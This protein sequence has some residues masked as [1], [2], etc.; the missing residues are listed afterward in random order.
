MS[1]RDE[2]VEALAAFATATDQ[3]DWATIRSLLAPDAFAYSSSGP[4]AIVAQMQAHLGGCGPTQHLLGNHR[5]TI[6]GDTAR[7]LSSARVHHVGAGP[8]AGSSYE[9]LGDYDDSWVPGPGG[10]RIVRRKFEIRIDR[11]DF[12]VL[13]P[14]DQQGA[15]DTP[16]QLALEARALELWRSEPV[17]RA[18]DGVRELY[19][20]DTQAATPSGLASV[21]SAAEAIAFVAALY[22]VIDDPANPEL[23]WLANAAHEWAALSVPGSGYGIDN[24]DNVHRRA[25]IDGVSEYVVRGSSPTGQR[26]EQQSF[27]VYAE[28]APGEPVTRE[29]ADILGVL[30]SDA[31][32]TNA[33]GTFEVTVGPSEA[34]GR[35]N[36]IQTRE[37]ATHLLVRDLLSDWTCQLPTRLSIERVS[38]APSTPASRESAEH[39][40]ALLAELGRYWV[41]YDNE[42]IFIRPVNE[43]VQPRPRPF[44]MSVAGHFA[45]DEGEGLL[46]T[47]DQAGARY[48]GFE[49]T[50]PWG[51]AREYVE[52]TGSLSSSQARAN[53]DGSITWII[54]PDDPGVWNWLDTAGLSCGM[55]A[56]RWQGG[57]LAEDPVREVRVVR[58]A[59]IT[60]DITPGERVAQLRERK[61]SYRR[62]LVEG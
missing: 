23:L 28:P 51:V 20:A 29:G 36:H 5:V 4:D 6:D 22:A 49:V 52:R 43:L 42:F 31:M 38:G 62:R 61:V 26:P 21:D 41:T 57:T 33:D 32:V 16:Q 25:A 8:K 10:W 11:G 48:I 24:P 1:A 60:P 18:A 3:R 53:A 56:I 40:A 59:D 58:L 30:V 2:I 27:I 19:R 17:R 46:V 37:G 50:D 13:R 15:L 35:P 45:L 44:G 55:L 34:D 7:S 54:S 9:C 12:G 39:A 47:V 14:T